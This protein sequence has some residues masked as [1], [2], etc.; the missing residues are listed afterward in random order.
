MKTTKTFENAALRTVN[1]GYIELDYNGKTECFHNASVISV[2]NGSIS[3]EV[4]WEPKEG[5]LVKIT[6]NYIDAYSIFHK[7]YKSTDTIL[8]YGYKRINGDNHTFCQYYWFTTSETE[9]HPVTPE[10]QETFDDFCKSKGKIWNKEKLQWEEYRWKPTIGGQYY[11]IDL[12]LLDGV[13]RHFY[14]DDSVD[15]CNY[16][17]YNCFKTKKEAEAKLE[18]IKKLLLEV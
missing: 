5:E 16:R 6:G 3:I 1:N 10:E 7:Y 4:D 13:G 18:Q 12:E 17:H 14:K 8:I 11:H 15:Q 9:I 2:N